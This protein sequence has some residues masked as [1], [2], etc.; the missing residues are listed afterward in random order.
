MPSSYIVWLN[1]GKGGPRNLPDFPESLAGI[2]GNYP[3]TPEMIPQ[4]I[5]IA[6]K[7]WVCHSDKFA[8]KQGPVTDH[9]K[10]MS[11]SAPSGQEHA[12]AE[13]RETYLDPSETV[14]EYDKEGQVDNL[15]DTD[16]DADEGDMSDEEI[17]VDD[18]IQGFFLHTSPIYS[19][20]LF[21]NWAVTGGGDDLGYV[22]DITNGEMIMKL[23]GH[24]DSVTNVAFSKDGKYLATGGMDGQVRVWNIPEK[25]LVVAYDGGD[26]VLVCYYKEWVDG[27]G[28]TGIH[29]DLS[30][31]PVWIT[32]QCGCGASLPTPQCKFSRGI[33]DLVR[34][35][36]S[37]QLENTS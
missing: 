3:Y 26:E 7:F 24:T 31:W 18:S 16:D 37:L 2:P 17:I 32:A 33:R 10:I 13:G 11:A 6:T 34:R 25:K 36:L 30:F 9:H 22:W 29:R 19:V 4:E 1:M 21:D 15:M 12:D 5:S 8:D 20:A 27:S 23:D 28:S 35:A 14:E